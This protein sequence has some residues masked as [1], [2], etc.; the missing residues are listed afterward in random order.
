MSAARKSIA[1]NDRLI[2]PRSG[3]QN[4]RFPAGQTA[5]KPPDFRRRLKLSGFDSG[6]FM[7]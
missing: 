5:D 1:T 6:L 7:F 4:R 2:V 3:V